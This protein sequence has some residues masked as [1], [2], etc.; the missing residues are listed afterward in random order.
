LDA[1]P[2]IQSFGGA[3]EISLNSIANEVIKEGFGQKN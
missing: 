1:A 3:Q 2:H